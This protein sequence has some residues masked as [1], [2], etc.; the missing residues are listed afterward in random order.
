MILSAYSVS[1]IVPVTETPT[2]TRS[3][4]CSQ[5]T[6]VLKESEGRETSVYNMQRSC[7][8][9][10]ETLQRTTKEEQL[11]GFRGDEKRREVGGLLGRCY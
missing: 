8:G 3:S 10:E 6:Y 4:V 7:Q 11:L 1:Q 9:A 2:R 5:G